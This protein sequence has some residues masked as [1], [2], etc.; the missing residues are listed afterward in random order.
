MH[1]EAGERRDFLPEL[2]GEMA[3]T[4]SRVVLESTIGCGMGLGHD[5]YL[6]RSPLVRMG[7]NGEAYQQDVVLVL[8]CPSDED[9]R[10]MRPGSTL[11]SMLH[12]PTRPDRVRRLAELGLHAISLD[13]IADDELARLV[14]DEA[15]VAW[16]GLEAAFDV[17]EAADATLHHPSR[18]PIRVTIMGAGAIG[19]HAVEAAT[20]YGSLE[21]FWRMEALGSPGVE[22][23]TIGRNLTRVP[24]YVRER[25]RVTDVLV[26]TTQRDDPSVALIPNE[27][28]VLLPARAVIADL[29]VD[30]Y[31]L[32]KD[33]P[34]VRAIEG[35]PWGDLDRYV[36]PPEDEAWE[37]TV[38]SSIPNEHRRTVV[39]CYSWPGVHPVEC[40]SLYGRQLAPLLRTLLERGGPQDLRAD[41]DDRERALLRASLDVWAPWPE[42]Q[43]TGDPLTWLGPRSAAVA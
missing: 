25:L 21:R 11:V 41:G 36:L 6:R 2:V 31:E 32:D 29:C 42:D 7:T 20:K 16:N 22:V 26:D 5:D 14:E 33:P 39:S 24:S 9:L 15:A 37:R 35:I 19:K 12:F 38:P 34:T 3:A 28:L 43:R 18:G 4:G 40:M 23:V 8:R 13:S 30:P 27:W 10:R 1:K 17:L